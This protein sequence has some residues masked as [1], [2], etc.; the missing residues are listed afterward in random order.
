MC[1]L[2]GGGWLIRNIAVYGWPDFL[3]QIAHNSV[4]IGQLRTGQRIAD[5]GLG[6]YLKEFLTTTYHSLWGQFGWMGV[7]MPDRVYLLIGIFLLVA[8]FGTLM[9]FGLFRNRLE[10]Q[11]WQRSG[12][13]VLASVVVAALVSYIGYNLTFVQFQGRYLY[14]MLI[15]MAGLIVLGLWGLSLGLE[16]LL[17]GK[18]GQ[19]YWDRVLPWLPLAALSWMPFL[20][21][22]ALFKY[23]V[24][25][26]R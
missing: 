18:P 19:A 6:A 14:T 2:I 7:P 25:N 8:L 22:W 17:Q 16:Q 23:I 13:W 12:E 5:I 26:L 24:P 3:G 11:P 1:L 20:T 15:P 10:L 21:L 4:V 9:T